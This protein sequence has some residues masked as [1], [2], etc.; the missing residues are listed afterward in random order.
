MELSCWTLVHDRYLLC[1][2]SDYAGNW[3]N[4]FATAKIFRDC[5]RPQLWWNIR[6]PFSSSSTLFTQTNVDGTVF[7]LSSLFGD[8]SERP[9]ISTYPGILD[10][11]PVAGNLLKKKFPNTTIWG[12]FFHFMPC[13]WWRVPN[14]GLT[15]EFRENEIFHQLMRWAAVLLL[16]SSHRVENVW[17]LALEDNEETTVAVTRFKD[18]VTETWIEAHFEYWNHFEH[19]VP[20]LNF[21]LALIGCNF[22][23]IIINTYISIRWIFFLIFS[24]KKNK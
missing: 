16:V 18:N 1:D 6:H 15:T 19:G 5:V 11:Q 20:W 22:L 10:N 13:V 4:V 14:C 21:H 23:Q 24:S 17:F 7:P 12:C 3:I 8:S 9:P 2:D